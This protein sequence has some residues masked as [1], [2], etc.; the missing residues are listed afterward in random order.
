MSKSV[1]GL[2]SAVLGLG[3]VAGVATGCASKKAEIDPAQMS[4]IEAAAS[5]AEAAANKAEAASHSATE[6]ASRAEAA[7]QKAEAIFSKSM[8]KR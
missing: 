2:A 6:A 8:H 1:R 3:L 5:K 7:A 4:R